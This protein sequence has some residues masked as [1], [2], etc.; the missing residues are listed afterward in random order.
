[1]PPESG[2]PEEYLFRLTRHPDKR[3]RDLPTI[4]NAAAGYLFAI[5]KDEKTCQNVQDGYT[6]ALCGAA[7][8]HLFT[9]DPEY[10]RYSP[11]FR[12]SAALGIWIESSIIHALAAA[13]IL[14]CD[15]FFIN[16][17][18]ETFIN[19]LSSKYFGNPLVLAAQRNHYNITKILLE[20][21]ANNESTA[22][23]RHQALRAAARAG[24][25]NIVQLVLEPQYMQGDSEALYKDAV[26]EAIKGGHASLAQSLIK[27]KQIDISALMNK[28]ILAAAVYHGHNDIVCKALENGADPNARESGDS[29][30]DSPLR[31]AAMKG[32]ANIARLLISHGAEVEQGG[33]YWSPL[34]AAVERGYKDITQILF[35]N[36]AD[37]NGQESIRPLAAAASHG[38]D[39][40]FFFLVKAGAD[41]SYLKHEN[42]SGL[43]GAALNGYETMINILISHGVDVR[44]AGDGP[45]LNAMLGGHDNVV[46]TLLEFGAEKPHSSVLGHHLHKCVQHGYEGS[47]RNLVAYGADIN[48]P[49]PIIKATPL[50]MAKHWR[51]IRV[52]NA[53]IELGAKFGPPVY[54]GLTA[55]R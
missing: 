40:M 3:A 20:R 38:Q 44:A 15:K 9:H 36:G 34:L 11:A 41:V 54:K 42:N 32:H 49:H 6:R 18:K 55:R 30:R 19:D 47:V 1:M 48:A 8:A 51:H 10:L 35:E 12:D 33:G 2:L 26:I 23:S 16:L 17:P 13:A 45:V 53:L 4:I 29:H 46:K 27:Q 37:I 28:R 5:T 21:N 24:H 25:E 7:A 50:C 31:Q 22:N 52:S 14:G 39:D 43:S